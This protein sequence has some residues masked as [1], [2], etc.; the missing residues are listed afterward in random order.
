M[1]NIVVKFLFKNPYAKFAK[2]HELYCCINII[3]GLTFF[4]TLFTML[5]IPNISTK[6]IIYTCNL[7]LFFSIHSM[8]LLFCV[9]FLS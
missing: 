9:A 1:N 3:L 4:L 6:F 5:F 7:G 2:K 8:Y